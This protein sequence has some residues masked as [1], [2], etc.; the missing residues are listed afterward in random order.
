MRTIAALLAAMAL[1]GSAE[2]ASAQEANPEPGYCAQFYP[3]ADCNTGPD[4][5][6][7]AVWRR[8]KPAAAPKRKR[9]TRS[10]TA[11]SK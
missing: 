6:N 1:T 8:P 11:L 5:T 9:R 2:R 7:V 4:A 3:N 10:A